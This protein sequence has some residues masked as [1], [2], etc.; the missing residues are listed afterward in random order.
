[1]IAKKDVALIGNEIIG[2]IATF[3]YTLIMHYKDNI[4][5]Y[6][7]GLFLNTPVR[8]ELTAKDIQ[9]IEEFDNFITQATS[10][11]LIIIF[12]SVTSI[13]LIHLKEYCNNKYLN[14]IV[15]EYDENKCV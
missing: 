12:I 13:T 15:D 5:W 9:E 8:L 11:F 6:V 2:T 4:S 10:G 3:I 14:R 7:K 1:M